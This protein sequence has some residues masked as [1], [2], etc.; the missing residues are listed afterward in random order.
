MR[1]GGGDLLRITESRTRRTTKIFCEIDRHRKNYLQFDDS[2]M[3]G[4]AK[5]G[6]GQIAKIIA[7]MIRISKPDYQR[8]LHLLKCVCQVGTREIF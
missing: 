2:K 8:N 6:T 3:I 7:Q 1:L 5:L 4:C